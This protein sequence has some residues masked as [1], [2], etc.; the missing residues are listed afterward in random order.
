MTDE[1]PVE[2]I[3]IR[4]VLLREMA[5]LVGVTLTTE[6]AVTLA[7]QAK[8]HFAQLSHLD[9]IADSHTEPAAELHLDR[10]TTPDSD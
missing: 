5:L 6:R 7:P 8:Q 1:S 10:W 9:A 3:A 4:S 2:P